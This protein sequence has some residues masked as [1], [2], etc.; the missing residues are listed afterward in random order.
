M[1]KRGLVPRNLV[2]S[3][4]Q[5]CDLDIHRGR[6]L[7]QQEP[8]LTRIPGG[9]YYVGFTLLIRG[10]KIFFR[11][12]PFERL[13]NVSLLQ[14]RSSAW[15]QLVGDSR[16]PPFHQTVLRNCKSSHLDEKQAHLRLLPEKNNAAH[17]FRS[18][19]DPVLPF[20]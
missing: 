15:V 19:V 5:R 9:F 14:N 7:V 2:H 8:D 16:K 6:K 10:R 13:E 12:E 20:H 11:A 3:S 1:G 18:L 17:V 4:A